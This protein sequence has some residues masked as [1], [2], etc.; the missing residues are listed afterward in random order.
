M[1]EKL[2]KPLV[3]TAFGKQRRGLASYM[4]ARNAL[5]DMVYQ[6]TQHAPIVAGDLAFASVG[7]MTRNAIGSVISNR[8]ADEP[9]A[10][11]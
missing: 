1:A 11:D 7:R 10:S 2:G 4:T 3:L 6:E 8:S 5:F 9:I